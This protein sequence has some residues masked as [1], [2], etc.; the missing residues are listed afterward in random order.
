[1]VYLPDRSVRYRID[2]HNFLAKSDI[3]FA[4]NNGWMLTNVA[5]KSDNTGIATEVI[6]A[7]T[8]LIPRIGAESIGAG[9]PV[10]DPILYEIEFDPVSGRVTKVIRLKPVEP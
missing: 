10:T 7:A 9:T 4:F 3:S 1:M 6:K 2:T 8:A 5:D